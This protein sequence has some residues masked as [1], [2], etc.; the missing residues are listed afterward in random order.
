[1]GLAVQNTDIRETET[2]PAGRPTQL[3][4]RPEKEI[5]SFRPW[6][7][8][9]DTI[10]TLLDNG[11][12]LGICCRDCP[13]TIEMKP[14]AIAERFGAYRHLKLIDLLPKLVCGEPAGCGSHDM[15]LFPWAVKPSAIKPEP[16][17]LLAAELPF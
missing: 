6:M 15:V 1:M 12:S 16:E 17:A 11:W 7:I 13:R 8:G 9:A 3:K 10:G 4:R 2:I 14:E 5:R